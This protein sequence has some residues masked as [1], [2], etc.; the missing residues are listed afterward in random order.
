MK[1]KNKLQSKRKLVNALKLFENKIDDTVI[2]IK[3]ISS[4]YY[5]FKTNNNKYSVDISNN[6]VDKV[7]D[8]PDW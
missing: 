6:T 2:N 1:R 7:Y 4:T 5:I 8:D 3:I